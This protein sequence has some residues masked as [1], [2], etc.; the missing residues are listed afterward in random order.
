MI[1]VNIR[2]LIKIFQLIL[3]ELEYVYYIFAVSLNHVITY[4]IIPNC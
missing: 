3:S 2:L 1:V 4:N